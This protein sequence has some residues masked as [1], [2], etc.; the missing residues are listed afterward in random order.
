MDLSIPALPSSCDVGVIGAGAAG[1][2]AAIF[3]RRLN[4]SLSVVLLDSATKP[5]AK[6]LVSGGGRCNV[7]N[8]AV[9]EADFWGGR[10]TMI[11]RV[12]RAFQPDDT[13]EFFR[14]LGVTLHEEANGKLFPDSNRARDVLDAL[15]G[16]VHAVGAMLFSGH[17]VLSVSRDSDGFRVT[18]SR[19]DLRARVVVLATGGQSLPKSGSDGTGFAIG[20]GLG[21]TLVPTTPGLVPLLIEPAK[22]AALDIHATRLRGQRP[23]L[24]D[25]ADFGALRAPVRVAHHSRPPVDDGILAERGRARLIPRAGV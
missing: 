17:R 1:L 10:R 8:A 12:L 14:E 22:G 24:V 3:T 13:V 19:G 16:E 21:H 7:T 9:S 25:V 2:A 5:G 4:P 15:L 18:T 11:R 23:R 20:R 6:I